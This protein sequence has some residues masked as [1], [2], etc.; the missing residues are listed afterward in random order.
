M[1]VCQTNQE[2]KKARKKKKKA[3]KREKLGVCTT[4]QAEATHIHTKKNER[5]H[6]KSGTGEGR[7]MQ[8][9]VKAAAEGSRQGTVPEGGGSRK[10]G[11]ERGRGR[12]V[13]GGGG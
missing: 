4:K 13:E 10:S 3:S 8:N 5:G 2:R 7:V 11:R 9:T 1:C 12:R 6:P